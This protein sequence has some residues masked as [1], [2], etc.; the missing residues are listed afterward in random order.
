MQLCIYSWLYTQYDTFQL[1]HSAVVF[2]CV[3]I[4]VFHIRSQLAIQLYCITVTFAFIHVVLFSSQLIEVFPENVQFS[5]LAC[6]YSYITWSLPRSL[7]IHVHTTAMYVANYGY[8]LFCM[9]LAATNQRPTQCR[10]ARPLFSR[11]SI[12]ALYW[13]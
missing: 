3:L 12:I 8:V 4:H 13:K 2:T 5:F 10:V 9:L 7:Q 6:M 1:R 11:R